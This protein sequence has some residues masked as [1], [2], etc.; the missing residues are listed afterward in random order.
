[1]PRLFEKLTIAGVGLIGGSLAL[2]AR[3]Q[4]LVGEIVGCG[5]T[6]ANLRTA[7]ERGIIDSYSLD[8][9]EAARDA[10]LLFLSV[11]VRAMGSLASTCGPV[12]RAGAIVTDA[13]SVKAAVVREIE[14]ALPDGIA[15]VGAHPIAGGEQAGAAA[16][17]A[18]VFQGSPCILTPGAKSSPSAVRK[19]R[20]LW[21]AVGMAVVEMDV[22]AHDALLARISHLPHVL[23]FA[24]VDSLR[25]R[26]GEVATLTGQSFRDMTRIA[27]SPSEVW[28]DI[29]VANRDE[30]T[31]ALDEFGAAFDELRGAIGRGDHAALRALIERA[32]RAQAKMGK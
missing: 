3:E 27:A 17:R 32:R 23:A 14:A 6:E 16:A 29:F 25:Q 19:I 2:A 26:S 21:E 10:D 24:L 5:R 8:P 13:G 7:R 11:P 28:A 31:A 4:G 18:D 1:M 12:L 22:D 30:L 9:R 20:A 15:F